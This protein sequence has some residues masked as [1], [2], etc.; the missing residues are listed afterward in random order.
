MPATV[1][2]DP[3]GIA[4][5]FS[6]GTSV[7]MMVN[8]TAGGKTYATRNPALAQEMLLGLADLVHPRTAT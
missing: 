8:V 1:L 5:V 6:D 3:L 2:E 4:A 7:S